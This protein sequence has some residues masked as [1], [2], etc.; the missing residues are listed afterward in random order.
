[1]KWPTAG[2]QPG[3]IDAVTLLG[4]QV[5]IRPTVQGYTYV[6]GD[7]E[8]FGPTPSPGGTYPDGD[9]THSYP[10]RGVYPTRIDVTYGG[11]FSV[12]DGDWITIP[13][14]VTV[15]GPD[16]LLTV[17]TAHARLVSR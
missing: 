14:T 10:K 12:D 3:E 8:S 16:Q 2:F 13:D 11:E 7:G 9:I 17:K 4:H 1:V 5:R 15:H 6:F